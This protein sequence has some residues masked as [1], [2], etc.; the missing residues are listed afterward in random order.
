MGFGDGMSGAATGP[1]GKTVAPVVMLDP[2]AERCV[3]QHPVYDEPLQQKVI[4]TSTTCCH[5]INVVPI[6]LGFPV[7]SILTSSSKYEDSNCAKV[8][9]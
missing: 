7:V 9:D 8:N 5:A 6:P 4:L 1:L 2:V 3:G